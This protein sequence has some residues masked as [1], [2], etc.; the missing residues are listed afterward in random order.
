MATVIAGLDVV[1]MGFHV[2]LKMVRRPPSYCCI[3]VVSPGPWLVRRPAL[4]DA[5]VKVPDARSRR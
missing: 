5:L 4:A 1:I 2:D 3:P